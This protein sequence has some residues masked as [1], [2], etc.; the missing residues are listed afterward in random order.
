MSENIMLDLE[1]ASSGVIEN[2]FRTGYKVQ[3]SWTLNSQNVANNTSNVTV[4]AQLVSTGGYYTISSSATK[5]GNLT[6][7]GTT[8]SF[9]FNAGLSA[10][11]TKTVFTKTVD[12]PHN[13]DGTKTFAMSTTLG[14][15]VT[16]SG[17]YWGNV[18]ANGNGTLN[19]IPRTSSISLS[20][21]SVNFGSAITVNISRASTAFTHRVHYVFGGRTVTFSTNATTSASYTIPLDHMNEIPYATSG[22]ASIYVDTYNGSTFIGTAGK[23]F[24]INVPSNIKPSISSLGASLVA[25]GLS[26]NFGYV[27]G[28]S[29]CKLT[30][31][32]ASG[33]YGS[34]ITSYSIS[35]GGFSTSSSSFTTGILNNSGSITFTAYVTDSR[36]RR[37]DNKTVTIN[38]NDYAPPVLHYPVVFRCDSSGNMNNDGTYIKT[39]FEY[40]NSEIV[41]GMVT[42]KV[43]FKPTSSSTWT[44]AGSVTS[45]RGLVFGSNGISTSSSYD[46]RITL[47]DT[48]STISQIF[49]VPTAFVTI[50]V[51]KG[52]KGVA[53]GK[54]SETD[55]LVDVGMN[56]RI[57]NNVQIDGNLTVSKGNQNPETGRTSN[58]GQLYTYNTVSTNTGQPTNY[59][60]VIGFGRG[61]AGTVEICGEWTSGRGLWVRALRDTTDNWFPW[62]R[63]YT[64][65]YKPTPSAIGA[66]P[67]SG[68]T[69][70]GAIT[71]SGESR[72]H[73]GTYSDPLEGTSCAIKA[74]G[75]I[76]STSSIHTK[77]WFY[78]YGSTGWYNGTHGGGWY[79]TDGTWL[80]SYN[81]KAIYTAGTIRTDGAVECNNINNANSGS[82]LDMNT[83]GK[84]FS[85]QT[86]SASGVWLEFRPYYSGSKGTE[87]TFKNGTGNGWGFVGGSDMP[88]YRV[89]GTGGSVSN[90]AKKYD[91]TK[92]DN[93]EQYENIRN[94]NIYNY[95]TLSDKLDEET[96]E[97]L[98]THK[99]SDL[100]LGC[101][102]DELPTETVFYDNEDGVGKAVDMYSY[103]TM[104]LGATKHLQTKVETLEKENE[105]L[106]NR[107]D[108]M[109]EL[110]NG[111]INEG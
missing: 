6:I 48:I 21:S 57:R 75:R 25:N 74:T 20:A 109:E 60:S 82:N 63:I 46:V 76:A 105:E 33:T 47:S 37:S 34:S 51:K 17:T 9:T 85:I 77:D 49:N 87:P 31:N 23:S 86:G 92:A 58:R 54:V 65:S 56:T 94:I 101:M 110:L 27:K 91:I 66:L 10:N 111:I 64:E 39:S 59:T 97:V 14:I 44:N 7:N 55:N 80:R 89:Y 79:M 11:Q 108:K 43:E 78:S 104:I 18:S 52:G 99:R 50:D 1:R 102:V 53:F 24:T 83:S 95:R 41:N 26:T 16:L 68:G 19:S 71:V 15:N 38:V 28:K 2:Q 84:S 107:L 36:G 3:I 22:T 61:T 72:F 90:R 69:L 42:N 8:Y 35:G 93:E 12:I 103:T 106:K 30:I 5:N 98:E 40:T 88:F 96:G 32:G 70:S 29:N 45:Q 4:K 62:T 81:N 73:N 100:M 13:S 67:T